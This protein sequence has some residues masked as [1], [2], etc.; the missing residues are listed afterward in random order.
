MKGFTFHLRSEM[1]ELQPAKGQLLVDSR[2]QIGQTARLMLSMLVGPQ[3]LPA[4]EF[5]QIR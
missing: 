5:S 4:T 3:T 1:A 2:L